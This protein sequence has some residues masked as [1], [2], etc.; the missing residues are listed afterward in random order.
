MQEGD[1]YMVE[2]PSTGGREQTG[3]RPAIIVQAVGIEKSTN[4]SHSS[5]Y[6]SVKSRRF[7]LHFYN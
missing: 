3:L 1:I 7:S 5:P 2:F 4:G 6:F